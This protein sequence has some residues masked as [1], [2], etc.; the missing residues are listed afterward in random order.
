[1][2]QTQVSTVIPYYLRFVQRFPDVPTLA[3][4]RIHS[5]LS[6]WS[7]L[8]YYARAH[9]LH[10]SA[11][12]IHQQGIPTTQQQW[13]ALPGIGQSTAAAIMV[14]AYQQRHAIL[15]GNVKRL[16]SRLYMIDSPVQLASTRQWM[17]EIAQSLLPP[18]KKTIVPYT[19][20]LMDLGSL[21]CKR[22]V[23]LCQQC[24]VNSHCQAFSQGVV[25]RYPVSKPPTHKPKRKKTLLL[26]YHRGQI[27][28]QR[29]L[30]QGI[31]AGLWSLPESDAHPDQLKNEWSK[32]LGSDLKKQKTLRFSHHFTHY[33]L[34]ARV[35]WYTGTPR[36]WV[37]QTGWFSLKSIKKMA[38]P[39]PIRQ[40][41]KP[42]IFINDDSSDR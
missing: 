20:G 41:L 36:K 10:Q 25:A 6:Q 4:A 21:I 37:S 23:P 39:A 31:W 1:M 27:L 29:R 12:Y 35:D 2:Q 16:L 42:E 3:N 17:W 9:H 5:V 13:Q 15:D 40:L 11:K 32:Q 14:F 18:T 30:N 8:G 26:I 7:G 38:L 22:S 19:Q 33:Q 24:P 34:I 28:L